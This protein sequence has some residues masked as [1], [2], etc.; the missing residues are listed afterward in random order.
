ME[1]LFCDYFKHAKGQEPS[2]SILKLF[3][4]ILSEEEDAQ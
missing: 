3:K 4:E 2:D 1:A